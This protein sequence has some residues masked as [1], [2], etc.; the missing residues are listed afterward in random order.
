MPLAN[1]LALTRELHR[2][3]LN[4]EPGG[5]TLSGDIIRPGTPHLVFHNR[6]LLRPLEELVGEPRLGQ[7]VFR[8]RRQ[9]GLEPLQLLLRPP[10]CLSRRRQP[11]RFHLLS[12]LQRNRVGVK[13]ALR[14]IPFI[15]C[16]R[17]AGLHRL[18]F[19]SQLRMIDNPPGGPGPARVGASLNRIDNPDR[20]GGYH[21]ILAK[22]HLVQN[23][24]KARTRV[25]GSQP[26]SPRVGVTPDKRLAHSHRPAVRTKG[27]LVRPAPVRRVVRERPLPTQPRQRL[28]RLLG[29]TLQA[30][31]PLRHLRRQNSFTAGHCQPPPLFGDAPATSGCRL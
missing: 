4:V 16:R 23:N 10:T 28:G 11:P 14:P 1:L 7:S 18:G 8:R 26:L 9:G 21:T 19:L 25:S 27:H 5:G 31:V 29:L 24:Q 17:Q 12:V 30:P 20:L 6:C 22:P 15:T 3:S 2:L 13:V